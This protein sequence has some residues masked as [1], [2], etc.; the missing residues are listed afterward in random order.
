MPR[1]RYDNLIHYIHSSTSSEFQFLF[2]YIL[3]LPLML[4]VYII[5]VFFLHLRINPCYT[6]CLKG[7]LLH[8]R[9]GCGVVVHLSSIFACSDLVFPLV[10]M[11]LL[12][13]PH[14]IALAFH[15]LWLVKSL[16]WMEIYHICWWWKLLLRHYLSAFSLNW[17]L[18]DIWASL[19][20]MLEVWFLPH[21]NWWILPKL[22]T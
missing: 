19:I 10:P 7:I 2:I 9:I 20:K 21:C 14:F 4:I 17:L 13:Y 16:W 12:T 15:I 11:L 8:F 5:S 6:W 22:L 3:W 1:S 18:S